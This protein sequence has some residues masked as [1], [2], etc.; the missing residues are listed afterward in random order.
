M[1]TTTA[2]LID[3]STPFL[4]LALPNKVELRQYH[5]KS[6]TYGPQVVTVIFDYPNE[7]FE[8]KTSGSGYCKKSEGLNIAFEHLGYQP[9]GHKKD[10]WLSYDLFVGGN[11]YKCTE[12]EAL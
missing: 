10:G 7:V 6:G 2:K 9:K 8:H 11:F 3:T 4:V 5:T 12:I 1:K